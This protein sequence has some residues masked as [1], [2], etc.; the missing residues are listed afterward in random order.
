MAILNFDANTVV[1]DTGSFEALPAGW[2]KVMME[3]SEMKPTKDNNGSYLECKYKILDGVH[4]GKSV[5]GR[6]NLRNVNAQAQEIA[7]KQL[8]AICHATGILQV[9]D[10]AQLHNIPLQIKLKLREARKELDAQGNVV[11]EYEASNEIS[12]YKNINEQVGAPAVG[13]FPAQVAPPAPAFMP[14]PAPPAFAPPMQ[15]APMQQAPQFAPPPAAAAPAAQAP[16]WQAP[17]AQQPWQAPAAAPIA[18]PQAPQYAPAS[19]QQAPVQQPQ[20]PQQYAPAPVP[21]VNPAVV[22]AATPPW[23]QP[24]APQ[25]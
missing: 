3:S 13:G 4:N 15:Q 23:M 16:Q 9:A 21:A 22:Q 2:Y 18:A 5:F 10:S 24:Q 19:V 7:Y 11:K 8:S 6:L 20:A 25:A 12:A 17:A 14:P 1:P